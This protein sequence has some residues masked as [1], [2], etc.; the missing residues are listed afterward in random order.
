MLAFH[1]AISI[2]QHRDTVNP[3]GNRNRPLIPSQRRTNAENKKTAA[4]S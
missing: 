1:D 2:Q 4:R 3:A